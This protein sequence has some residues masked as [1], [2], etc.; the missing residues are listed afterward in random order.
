MP[1]PLIVYGIVTGAVAFYGG[2]V[3]T[4][5]FLST[6]RSTAE[7]EFNSRFSDITD[8][9]VRKNLLDVFT[10][11]YT[12]AR[13]TQT[14]GEGFAHL[15]G[16]LNELRG[17]NTAALKNMDF[18]NNRL[19]RNLGEQ[20]SDNTSLLD[21][22][23][24]AIR[25]GDTINNPLT[26]TRQYSDPYSKLTP[27]AIEEL[28][29]LH[30]LESF[31]GDTFDNPLSWSNQLN[32]QSND[33]NGDGR[34]D[35]NGGDGGGGDGGG[36]NG[37]GGG[38][39]GDGPDLPQKPNE[40]EDQ[41]SPL[42]LDLDGDGIEL[43]NV[44]AYGTY[45]DLLETGQAVLTGWVEP[46]DGL[47]AI[48]INNDGLINNSSEL[49]GNKTT[50]GFSELRA[51]DSNE[52]G[53]IN[54][55][56]TVFADLLVWTD[57]NSDGI[58]Q[59][60]E[61]HTLSDLGIAS[62]SLDANLIAGQ[63]VAGNTITHEATYT[64]N[65]GTER[66]IVDAW[67]SYDVGQTKNV[68]DYDFDIQ[69]AF[70][71]TFRG[72]GDLKDFHIALSLDNG[73]TSETL[74]TQVTD[75]MNGIT[76][77]SVFSDFSAFDTAMEDVLLRWA[78]VDGID[79]NSR[80]DY[81]DG[82][83]LAFNEAV[84]GRVF[85]QYGQPDPLP[86]AG[87]YSE[88][89]YSYLKTYYTAQFIAQAVGDEIFVGANYNL[90]TAGFTGDL[91]LV[92]SGID[93]IQAVASNVNNN[94]VDVWTQFAQFLGYAKGFDNLTASEITALDTAVLATGEIS[95]SDWQDVV[96]VMTASL[97]SI[98]D[99][100]DD[101]GSFEIFYDN[102]LAGTTGDDIIT[103]T[104][105]NGYNDNELKGRAGND[106]L[107][108]LDGHDKLIGGLGNDTLDGGTGDDYLLGGTGD[109]VY[110]YTAGNDTISE[111][112][113]GG[114]DE[115]RIAASTGLTQAN[116]TD[117]YRHGDDLILFFD[118][119]NFITL[120]GYNGQDTRIEKIVFETDSTEIDLT[121]LLEEKFYGTDGAD[122]LTVSGQQFQT[123]LT[124]GYAGNDTLQVSGSSA[125]FY[126][127]DGYD[128]L[129]GSFVN[130]KLYGEADDDYLIGNGGDDILEGGAGHDV[131]DGGAGNDVLF[132]GTGDDIFYYG[133]GY[134]DDL[135][136]RTLVSNIGELNNDTI[137]F[138]GGLL[139]SDISLYREDTIQGLRDL[140]FTITSSGETLTIEDMYAKNN[141]WLFGIDA[142]KF[143]DGT[144]WTHQSIM[145]KYISDNT[146]AG[147]DVTLGFEKDDVFLSSAGDD[148]LKGYSGDDTYHWG[149][150]AG[151]DVIY[152]L[153]RNVNNGNTIDKVIF[154]SLNVS[155][156]IFQAD[157][158]D[159]II[160]NSVTLETLTINNQFH[161]L[162]YYHIEGFE[163]A[164]GTILDEVAIDILAHP[165]SGAGEINGTIG[166]DTIYGD[167]DGVADD[168]IIG[169]SGN[170]T[171]RGY[172]GDDS[173]VWS[174]G[175]GD[176][177]IYDTQGVDQLILHGVLASEITF[178][179]SGSYDLRVHMGSESILLDNQLKSD[180]T[181]TSNYDQYQIETALLDDG[182]VVNLLND[183]TF[184]GTASSE[185]LTGL[186]NGND[187]LIGLGGNDTLKGYK[188]DDSY[189]W[190]V[191]DGDDT[192]Y[193]TGGVDQLVLH[194][195]LASEITFEKSGNYDLRVHI[196]SE[197][198]L[199]D[200]QLKSD[201]VNTM[202]YDKYQ[203]ETLLLDD[204]S[205]IDI[206]NN[207][208]FT[209]TSSGETVKGL[210]NG[211]DTL[212]ALDGNDTLYSYAGDDVLVG[213]LGND[214]LRGELGNDNYIWSV[215][216]G[217]DTIYDTGGVDQ[218]VLHGV[219]ANEVRLEK[220]GVYDLELHIGSET[221]LLDNQLKS[222]YSGNATYD[223]Y[224]IETILLDNGTVID[225][226]DNLTF[227]GT[228]GDNT[229]TGSNGDDTLF[230]FDGNDT[231]NGDD[232]HDT[233][234]GG[235]GSDY[236]YGNNGDDILSGGAGIDMLY[237][238]SGADTF[239][240]EAV[241]AFTNSDNVQ[242]FDLSEGDKI[243]I[244]DVLI[245]YD[246]LTD[247][248]SDFVQITDDGTHSTLYVDADG[249]ADNF[250]Q[251]ASMF[252]VTGLTDEDTLETSGN[253]V[254]V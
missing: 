23:E 46:D 56:D 199:L 187:V 27:E 151:N 48:D 49:F 58:S 210:K 84:K 220:S 233:L 146:T 160:T 136:Q 94:A 140:T 95:L 59:A 89:V 42:V 4:N 123:L 10:H 165:S 51:Y 175:D 134:G 22:I 138:K 153:T 254:T 17:G 137:I 100:S 55:N 214:T 183:L 88:A 247:V 251:V 246:E 41:G 204:G 157:V 112:N 114:F 139:P 91:S 52:D 149:A 110:I 191:G 219:L 45:F 14:T 144:V 85:S 60:D 35:G 203:I 53:V 125:K 168:T 50:D 57:T 188:G 104:N 120:H 202:N 38:D 235:H 180:Y 6:S 8:A 206:L 78:G 245:G 117:L 24:S 39:G 152:D 63:E 243:D 189:V 92:Q 192:I 20:I 205:V 142:F 25:N 229:L 5:I 181:S 65:N 238:Q 133:A 126:G 13:I 179:K 185:T 231:L 37:G 172:K 208:T 79:P 106:T 2:A 143:S 124:Y 102:F 236:L 161:S 74:M 108:G 184:I 87:E 200:N 171:L 141:F 80:G 207:L 131:L 12:S 71:P 209:G 170:D 197:S 196:G 116:M 81:V 132:G 93:A 64:L 252:N 178:E 40:E 223:K 211:D 221:I 115:I 182:S 90:Y 248:I 166:N 213:G 129:I 99:S 30:D 239:V 244:S 16:D 44:G 135:I 121:N 148:V 43:Y 7:T 72:F 130:D 82:Q 118:T 70:L 66:A 1:V 222:D 68:A 96:N 29:Q 217:N 111:E 176:D 21:A 18:W 15:L 62:I 228:S 164:D 226:A 33:S 54:S 230:G 169:L 67:F 11:T 163:F 159:L 240:F 155:D 227:N 216:D 75:L 83:H 232:G 218:L 32:N 150:G 190:S 101:W 103:D 224:H 234:I 177:T 3:G 242:D 173:Y 19:G 156:L 119:G 31:D 9:A 113:G 34:A 147:A 77:T 237:G 26:D 193:D 61:L 69:T 127:G 167:V 241:S 97:G 186:S 73:T 36:G 158:D 249:G 128:T 47:L 98:I 194:G 154:D 212:Y 162:S 225:I 86:E 145:D 109:D 107:E 201:Y 28:S 105:A 122:D 174:V 250:V 198:I 76:L 215:G 195:I 253:L